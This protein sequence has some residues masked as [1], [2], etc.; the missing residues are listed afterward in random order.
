MKKNRRV[1]SIFMAVV[2]LLTLFGTTSAV[3]SDRNDS[4][5][6]F[7]PVEQILNDPSTVAYIEKIVDLT[8]RASAGDSAA[9]NALKVRGKSIED[10]FPNGGLIGDDWRHTAELSAINW[11]DRKFTSANVP[12]TDSSPRLQS[13]AA[14]GLVPYRSPAPSFSRNL[15]VTRDVGTPIQ[16]EPHICVSPDDPQNLIIASHN[17]GSAAPPTHVS[18]DGGETWQGPQRV[19]LTTGGIFGSDPVLACGRNGKTYYSY[20]SI[21]TRDVTLEGIPLSIT[22]IDIALSVSNDGGLIWEEPSV[23]STNRFEFDEYEVSLKDPV[24]GETKVTSI[25]VL[26]FSFLDKNWV[27]VGP[28]PNDPDK[29]V[30]YVSY[31]KF[32]NYMILSEP[33]PGLLILISIQ[34]TS[35]IEVFK[36]LD[37]GKTWGKSSVMDPVPAIRDLG[38]TVFSKGIAN[39]FTRAVQGSQLSVGQ[40]G[41]V[42]VAWLDST[43]DGYAMGKSEYY[44]ASSDNTGVSWNG[45]VLAAEGLEVE[46]FPQVAMFRNNSMPQMGVGPNGDV[47]LV[48]PSRTEGKPTDEGD[49]YFVRGEPNN[50]SLVF[51]EPQKLN[52]D[53]T[54][55]MQ[56][57]PAL[58][59]GPDGTIHV[60]WGDMR[61]DP[62]SLKYHIY[63]SKSEDR[64][65]TWGFEVR[66]IKEPDTRVTDFPSNPNKGFPRGRFIG[67][68]FGIVASTDDVYMV[69]TDSRLGEFGS[70]NQKIGFARK[71]AIPSPEIFMNPSRGSSGQEVIVQAFNFQPDMSLF[72]RLGGNIVAGGRTNDEGR[73]QFKLRVPIVASEGTQEVM[74]FDESGNVAVASFFVDFGFNDLKRISDDAAVVQEKTTELLAAV[75]KTKQERSDLNVALMVLLVLLVV[76]VGALFIL[77]IRRGPRSAALGN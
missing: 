55:N 63:Y 14:G 50:G 32:T 43:Y 42:Y 18:F 17:Y 66:G 5:D 68:Y 59:V 61:D 41:R 72:V 10:V 75:N 44:V 28:N 51:T 1:L 3:A 37:E 46:F 7:Y 29:D 26:A 22:K 27:A 65:D 12:Q 15:L 40:D 49:I 16:N 58:A 8:E 69:W 25:P 36:S 23:V 30:L 33:I 6:S 31:T 77:Q 73:L 62:M 39:I 64:G 52:Q 24:S 53:R 71:S 34:F 57:F 47:Y 19:S 48:Y 67:D 76:M 13:A 54:N 4:S 56:F 74:V 45:P 11:I 38:E 2:V 70:M 35:E 9:L 20:M 60:M 21:G